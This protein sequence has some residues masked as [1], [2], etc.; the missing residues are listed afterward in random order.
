MY[1]FQPQAALRA[2][3]QIERIVERRVETAQRNVLRC[4]FFPYERR[5]VVVG[6]PIAGEGLFRAVDADPF[7]E[8]LVVLPKQRQQHRR[9]LPDALHGILDR[10]GRHEAEV[11]ADAFVM[12]ADDLRKT[13]DRTVYLRGVAAFA[14]GATRRRIP[15]RG[16]YLDLRTDLFGSGVDADFA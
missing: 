16:V 7:A 1:G 3:E 5:E 11:A 14:V 6:V 4:V 9:L 10:F 2:Q 15:E 12:T 8:L 13:V